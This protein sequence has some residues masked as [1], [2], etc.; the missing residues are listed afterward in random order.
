MAGRRLTPE[1]Q[2]L[3]NRVAQTVRPM[4]RRAL[5]Q[6]AEKG[7]EVTPVVPVSKAIKM[8][9][10]S[11][12]LLPPKPVRRPVDVLDSNWERRIA[13]GAISPDSTIDLHGHSLDAAHRRLET[14]LSSALL[15]G[16]RVL[17]VVTGK[18][19]A[20][21]LI[22]GERVRGAIRAEIG[23]W[24]GSSAHADAIASVRTAHPRHGGNGAIYVIL[25]RYG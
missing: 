19:R 13:K 9:Q 8:R 4:A 11:P 15:K 5:I 1:E 2:A 21:A 22:G 20:T 12:V 23:H 10:S 7:G 18:P 6:T 3:W 16:A 24:L 14:A 17:L 25:R